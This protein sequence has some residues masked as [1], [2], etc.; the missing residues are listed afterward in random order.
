M[1]FIPVVPARVFV[2]S[3]TRALPNPLMG[4]SGRRGWPCFP[5]EH[6]RRWAGYALCLRAAAGGSMLSATDAPKSMEAHYPP[7]PGKSDRDSQNQ[8]II[9]TDQH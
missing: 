3:R 1:K 9:A 2:K 8:R 5:A 4:F 7:R 6:G